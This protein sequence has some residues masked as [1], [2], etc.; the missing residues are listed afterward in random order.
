[1]LSARHDRWTEFLQDYTYTLKHMSGVENK[2][3][4]ALSRR[5]CLLIQLSAEVVR[6]ERIKEEHELCPGFEK[7]VLVLK[8]RM[9]P[10]IDGF[11]LQD[12]YLF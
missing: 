1:M 2:V 10:E 7:N 12:G 4:D 9:T 6:F 3:A 5:V 8:E 11:L